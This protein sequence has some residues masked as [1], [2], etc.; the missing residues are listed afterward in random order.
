MAFFVMYNF[1]RIW[2]YLFFKIIMKFG[3]DTFSL[4]SLQHDFHNLLK[5]LLKGKMHALM[6]IV[7]HKE[8]QIC[9]HYM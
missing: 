1:I 8:C 5:F 2:R 4:N 6:L 7:H 3:G 9:F